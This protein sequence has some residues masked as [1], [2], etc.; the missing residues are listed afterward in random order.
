M[1]ANSKVVYVCKECGYETAKV[2]KCPECGSKYI[3]GFKVG[4]QQIEDKLKELFPEIRVLRMDADTTMARQSHEKLLESFKN[5]KGKDYRH[6][7][8]IK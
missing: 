5:H 4:T 6:Y 3:L 8:A 2:T 1:A 7:N